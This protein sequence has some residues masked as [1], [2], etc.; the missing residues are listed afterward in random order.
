MEVLQVIHNHL[1][2][3]FNINFLQVLAKEKK[4]LGYLMENY[5]NSY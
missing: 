1:S 2:V 5:I 3:D 4:S